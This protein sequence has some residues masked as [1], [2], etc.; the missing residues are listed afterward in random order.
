MRAYYLSSEAPMERFALPNN[1]YT[2]EWWPTTSHDKP[3]VPGGAV[4]AVSWGDKEVRVIYG[5][6]GTLQEVGLSSDP[7]KWWPRVTL[8]P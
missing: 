7:L 2:E 4:A 5:S 3:D 8:K 1:S 6:H